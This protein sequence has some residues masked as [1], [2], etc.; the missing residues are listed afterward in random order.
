[1]ILN[2][3]ESAYRVDKDNCPVAYCPQLPEILVQP[4]GYDEA[5]VLLK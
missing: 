1:M 5:E 4:I 2:Y 3:T